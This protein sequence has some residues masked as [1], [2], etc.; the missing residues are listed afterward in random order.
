[1]EGRG[2]KGGQAYDCTWGNRTETETFQG[3]SGWTIT[4][5]FLYCTRLALQNGAGAAIEMDDG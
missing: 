2:G 3:G 5:P 1:M 4:V